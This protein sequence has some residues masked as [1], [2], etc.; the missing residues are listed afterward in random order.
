MSD[1]KEQTPE[2]TTIDTRT[3]RRTIGLFAT[4]VTVVAVEI[5]GVQRGMTANA[6]A[7]VSLTPPLVLV[8]VQKEAQMLQFLQKSAGFSINIL[9]ER[10][11][12]LSRY[13]ANMW[14]EATPPP[15]SFR[16]W[17]GGPRL[18]GAIGAVAC[19]T[20]EYLEGGDHWIVIGRVIDL[21]RAENP[22]HPLLFY[23]GQ[24]RQMSSL[25]GR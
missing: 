3:F 13:F 15:F 20:Q 2:Q 17:I 19:E 23:G 14:T 1:F 9:S 11:E 18:E 7:S 8:C 22:E 10:Q 16:P 25:D 5:D 6:V 24:Y 4:G 12:N 21:Y